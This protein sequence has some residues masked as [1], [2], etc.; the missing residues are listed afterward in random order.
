MDMGNDRLKLGGLALVVGAVMFFVFWIGP[1]TESDFSLIG[2]WQLQLLFH[3]VQIGLLVTGLL[4]TMR[5]PVEGWVRHL[6]RIGAALAALGTPISLQV[7]AFGMLLLGIGTAFTPGFRLASLALV[8]GAWLWLVLFIEGGIIGNESEP[9]L[10]VLEQAL[11]TS[12][13]TL[14]SFGLLLL[15]GLIFR[16][17]TGVAGSPEKEPEHTGHE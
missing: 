16:G 1:A 5:L 13:L 14:I 10:T 12:G 2:L 15:G 8:P 4:L 9:P 3:G 6:W 11:A 17:R 7:F